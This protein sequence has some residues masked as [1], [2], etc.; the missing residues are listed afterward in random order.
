MN[1]VLQFSVSHGGLLL[2]AVVL[3]EQTGLPI[4]AAPCLLAAGALCATGENN[5]IEAIGITVL[6]CL[7]ADVAWFYV[8]RRGGKRVV[9]LLVRL[10]L[11]DDSHLARIERH[12]AR[13]RMPVV[14]LAKFIPGLSI[15]APPLAGA[16][17]TGIGQ[18]LLFD[19]LGSVLYAACYLVLGSTFNEQVQSI[20]EILHQFGLSTL[21]LLSALIGVW[22]LLRHIPEKC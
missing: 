18:F 4:P 16:L 6:A 15:V 8:G 11:S 17:G 19:L 9:Q 2:F 13:H 5:P 7:I 20:V 1:E 10:I 12:F 3:L 21:L 14:A 22:I